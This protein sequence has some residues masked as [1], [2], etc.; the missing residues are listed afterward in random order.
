MWVDSQESAEQIRRQAFALLDAGRAGEAVALAE[1]LE[2]DEPARTSLQALI[3]TEA[4]EALG[5]VGVLERGRD[6]WR[7]L[8]VDRS[9]HLVY[10][11]ANAEFALWSVARRERRYGE[12]LESSRSHLL[13]ARELYERAASEP[14][15]G[16]EVRVQALTNLGNSFDTMGRE[17][18]GY[19]CW[20]RVTEL[21]PDFGMAHGNVGVALAEVAAHLDQHAATARHRAAVALDRALLDREGI[22]AYG[23]PR[24]LE[25]FEEV[26]RGLPEPAAEADQEDRVWSDPYLEWCRAN[27]LFL[28]LSPTCQA[29]SDQLLD[30][31]YIRQLSSGAADDQLRSKTSSMPL[32]PSSRTSSRRATRPGW[33]ARRRVR[34]G[35]RPS[36]S[37]PPRPFST[38][39]RTG[40]GV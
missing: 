29:E 16:T 23:G 37:R 22:L 3:F 4:G 20:S 26:R 7:S 12:A 30:P 6:G 5:D 33:R 21:D 19:R 25:R 32:T 18:D 38:A 35:I 31:L 39:W 40:A 14:S 24:A 13:S 1:G 9:P 15:A 11:L 27:Q 8:D 28:H 2:G 34:S 17:I 10:N 36:A